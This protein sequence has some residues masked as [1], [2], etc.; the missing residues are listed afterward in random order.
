VRIL[1]LG[2]TSFLGRHFAQQ[3]VEAGHSVTLF[4]RGK[5]GRGV[6][7]G[8]EERL[9]D[10]DGGLD[11]L[12]GGRWDVAVDTC[13]Y[14]P[15]VV[16][17]SVRFLKDSVDH[18]TFV[19][20]ISVYAD[21]SAP[22]LTE[23]G[24]LLPLPEP[25][26]ED[27][28][29]YYGA[30]KAVCER[31]VLDALGPRALIVRP[32][33]IVGPYDPTDRFTYWPMRM[34]RPGPVLAPGRP[35]RTVQLIDARDLGAW[36]L[37]MAERREAGVYN[38]TGPD[39]PLS[40]AAMIEACGRGLGHR[41][42]IVWVDDAFLTNREVGAWMEL[43]L[44]LPDSAGMGGMLSADVSRAVA[45]GLRFRP[46]E[47]IARDTAAWAEGE[48]RWRGRKAGMAPRRERELLAAW[49]DSTAAASAG[50]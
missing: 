7:V 40:M 43:P 17:Q 33:L 28:Q 47:E 41:P 19:S 37:D 50:L 22:G 45:K 5:T 26:S 44:W 14:V 10:R 48:G 8:A 25:A 2:G 27:V 15:R 24:A 46:L 23:E 34:G 16:E 12:A 32:G 29:K 9:G 1:V 13:G 21:F 18:Y 20:T 11:A 49:R 35:E 42:R 36:M 4:H 3:A 31:V 38:A 30:L 39:R 6:V